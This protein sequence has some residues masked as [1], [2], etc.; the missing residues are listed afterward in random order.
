MARLSLISNT[1]ACMYMCTRIR[2]YYAWTWVSWFHDLFIKLKAE[3]ISGLE[4]F[5][6]SLVTIIS[7]AGASIAKHRYSSHS[8]CHFILTLA[9]FLWSRLFGILR[10][11]QVKFQKQRNSIIIHLIKCWKELIV[12]YDVFIAW[13][14]YSEA[15]CRRY[16][17]RAIVLDLSSI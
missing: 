16:L 5:F 4:F 12:S 13:C 1:L 2:V 7:F 3:K 14:E 17:A 6:L 8:C 9:L 10:N 15:F 11:A